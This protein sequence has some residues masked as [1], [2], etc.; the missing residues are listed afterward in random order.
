MTNEKILSSL[1]GGALGDA[2]GYSREFSNYSENINR[3]RN[4]NWRNA[5]FHNAPVGQFDPQ[6]HALISDD[7][8]MTIATG[9]ALLGSRHMHTPTYAAAFTTHLADAYVAWSKHPDNNRAPGGACMRA[10]ANMAKGLS[11]QDATG[12]QAMGC[13]ANMRVAPIALSRDLYVNQTDFAALSSAITHAHPG[14][15]AATILTVQAIAATHDGI[16][17]EELLDFLIDECSPV[18]TIY[19]TV[20]GDLW[21]QSEYNSPQG[22][23]Q[24][25]YTECL[26][27]L[28][29]ARRA[30]RAGWIGD[31]D[32][33]TVTGD[34]WTA[35]Q[36]LAGAVLCTVALWDNPVRVLQRA[37]VSGG[38]SDSLAAI[39]GNIRGAAGVEWPQ[40]WVSTLEVKP[41]AELVK[42][43]DAL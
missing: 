15:I 16:E 36:A 42:L 5:N 19:P 35:P 6:G 11:W 33:C 37:A 26:G 13:G 9:R 27:Y 24:A 31:G 7:T 43:A 3:L 29:R 41:L 22:Y 4:R 28:L 23:I 14:A 30:L 8:Q 38:D 10:C 20:L 34:A 12:I 1:I 18:A 17:G 2:L 32:P 40:E 39:A 21:T 25:G